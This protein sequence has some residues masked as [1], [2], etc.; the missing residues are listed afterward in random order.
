ME[1]A[2]LLDLVC[3]PVGPLPETHQ[4]YRLV[5]HLASGG[6]A[7]VYRAV[8]VSGGISSAPVTVKVFRPGDDRPVPDQLRSWDKGDAVLMD[9]N[10]RGVAGIC[11]RADGFYAPQPS[12]PGQS[13]AGEP[14]PYQVLDYLH[15][16]TMR[17]YVAG[18]YGLAGHGPRLDAVTALTTL[19]EV[20]RALHLPDDPRAC[21]VLHM[22]VKPANVMLLT[23]GEVRLIDFTGARYHW[24]DHIT[25]VA[26]TRES[27]GPEA[28]S[29]D[30]GPAYDVHGFGAVAYYLV[31]GEFP[32]AEA[33]PPD[34]L[35]AP[36]WAVLRR[37]PLLDAQPALREHLLAPVADRPA[38]RPSTGE[39]PDWV[40]RL[41]GLVA[42]AG[43]PDVGVDWGSPR[44]GW[45]AAQSGPTAATPVAGT[46]T[47]AF[48]RI[49]KLEREL[50]E[51]RTVLGGSA[52]SNGGVPPNGA[53]P[54]NGP[55]SANGHQV[56]P[57]P[58]KVAAQ[59]V[60]QPAG[61]PP[62]QPDPTR[63]APGPQAGPDGSI[64]GRA[65][66][67]P[68]REPDP[69]LSGQPVAPAQPRPDQNRPRPDLA[70][71][72]NRGSEITG[73][74]VMF[75]FVCWGIWSVASGRG[76]FVDKFL[77]FVFVLLI[78]GGVFILARLVG[79]LVWERLL[80]RVRRNARGAHAVTAAYLAA[81]G[82]GFLNATSW[83]MEL[84][85]W[86]KSLV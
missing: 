78:G 35:V 56:R 2:A 11:R 20:L 32:R 51:L 73:V 52:L 31:T 6:Q 66:V 85:G 84:W 71:V 86:L 26:Y 46:E 58:T 77:I 74:G 54:A 82:I 47:G 67:P 22:D 16:V 40:R 60:G 17:E 8:R 59:P 36:P 18:R 53:V 4:R 27:A 39:L 65:S 25:G 68:P 13:P 21:P 81:A 7:E 34:G 15:G 1:G 75:V 50:V 45:S 19:A 12:P 42:A 76:G 43:C 80:G 10:S 44:Q 70:T 33:S 24:R 23:G 3:G 14:V 41:G 48:Q 5:S 37:H 38:D 62:R 49:E 28:F 79:R 63:V 57:Q 72:L 29:G 64:R 83:V 61:Q 55:G 9:L 69:T 30:V